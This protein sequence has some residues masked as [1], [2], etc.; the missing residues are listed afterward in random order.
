MSR[1]TILIEDLELSMYLGL[2]DFEKKDKQRVLICAEIVVDSADFSQ[3]G[4][5][6]YDGVADFI[7]TFNGARIETQEELI[8]TIHLYIL[9]QGAASAKVYSRKPDVY[10]DC[11]SV[12]VSF[13][14]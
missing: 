13:S 6:D 2:H 8:Q 7:R 1:F 11:K 3:D 4:F 5:L 10:S 12:G 9:A 14:G